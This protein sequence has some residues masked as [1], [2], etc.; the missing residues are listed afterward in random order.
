[1]IY[2]RKETRSNPIGI[3]FA[4]LRAMLITLSEEARARGAEGGTETEG[5]EKRL[6]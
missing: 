2:E 5:G 6:D 4:S 3:C 1:M